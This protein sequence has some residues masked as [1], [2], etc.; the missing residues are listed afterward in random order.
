MDNDQFCACP[1]C[2]AI[3]RLPQSKFNHRQG[4]VRCGACREVFDSKINLVKRS[5]H[6]FVP[7]TAADQIVESVAKFTDEIELRNEK[8][9]PLSMK[10]PSRD[11]LE[12]IEID[13]PSEE[14]QDSDH[15]QHSGH[16]IFEEDSLTSVNLQV[17][18]VRN[19]FEEFE[20]PDVVDEEQA[21]SRNG[22]SLL[23]PLNLDEKDSESQ[24]TEHITSMLSQKSETYEEVHSISQASGYDIDD[25]VD[26]KLVSSGVGEVNRTSHSVNLDTDSGR[27]DQ[28]TLGRMSLQRVDRM[29]GY[30][31]NPLATF[32]WI[33]VALGFVVL[34]GLQVKYFF[35]EKYAQDETYRPYLVGFCKLAQC[36]LPPRQDPY[37]YTLTHT[38]IDLHPNYPGAL[39]VTVK[40]VNEAGYAQPFPLLQLTLTDR[41]GRVVGRRTFE[42]GFYLPQNTKNMLGK[43]ELASVIFDLARP[44]EKAVGFVV[45]IVTEPVNS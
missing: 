36:E 31:S 25:E 30:Q 6:G 41:V 12:N 11:E 34:L 26:L 21:L 13:Q 32:S 10:I 37:K 4:M 3:F 16:N 23:E 33:I 43:G 24:Y 45:D 38:K 1:Y 35:V 18:S 22:E 29:I 5:D 20:N 7:V 28:S 40:L 44:H 27:L 9:D 42:P 2:K 39:R 19:P 8:Y 15:L 17:D 14:L